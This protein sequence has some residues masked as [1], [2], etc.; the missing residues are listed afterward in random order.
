[1]TSER[2]SIESKWIKTQGLYFSSQRTDY[3]SFHRCRAYL[4]KLKNV[5]RSNT[6]MIRPSLTVSSLLL[7]FFSFA[8]SL[9]A[10]PTSLKASL[11]KISHTMSA[12]VGVAIIGPETNDT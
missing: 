8:T 1:M 7:C 11:G 10:Q 9:F 2:T 12:D 5:R 3:H 6:M 4:W